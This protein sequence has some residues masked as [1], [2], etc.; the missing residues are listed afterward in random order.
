[1]PTWVNAVQRL[2]NDVIGDRVEHLHLSTR[3][4]SS[5]H[6]NPKTEN[7]RAHARKLAIVDHHFADGER[8]L[9]TGYIDWIVGPTSRRMPIERVEL[10]ADALVE[11]LDGWYRVE[12]GALDG[13]IAGPDGL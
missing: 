7:G 10:L 3:R 8:W 4:P 9:T 5:A 12:L 2:R 1:M 11:I 6:V 13:A